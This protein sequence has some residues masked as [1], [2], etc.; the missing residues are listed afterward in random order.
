MCTTD[1][2]VKNFS[3]MDDEWSILKSEISWNSVIQNSESNEGYIERKPDVQLKQKCF[4][5]EGI[6]FSM[7]QFLS[8]L[9]KVKKIDCHEKTFSLTTT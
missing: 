9:Y 7:Q 8:S 6:N 5:N 1:K 3:Q 4:E 2:T